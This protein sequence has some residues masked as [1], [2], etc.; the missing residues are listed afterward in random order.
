MKKPPFQFGL[1]TAFAAMT[2]VAIVAAVGA[3]IPPQLA[4]ALSER[5]VLWGLSVAVFFA[6]WFSAWLVGLVRY[7]PPDG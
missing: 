4:K 7:K 2:G 5:L 6:L 3:V 1:K